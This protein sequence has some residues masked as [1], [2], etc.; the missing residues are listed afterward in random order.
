VTEHS[1]EIVSLEDRDK[2]MTTLEFAFATDPV[3]RWL[4][5]SPGAFHAAFS[6]FVNA[7]AGDAFDQGTA[8]WVDDGRGVA[9]WLPPGFGADDDA[10]VQVI[11]ESVNPDLLTDLSEFSDLLREYHPVVDHW[12]LAVT[13]VDPYC[14]GTGLGS[15][16]LRHALGRCDH[17]GLPAYLE[18]STLRNRALYERFGFKEIGVIQAG[19]SPQVWAMMRQPALT[20]EGL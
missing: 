12:Y 5:P 7:M 8:Q 13:G 11:L 17:D 2:A 18:A 10:L 14:Q 9:L 19:T 16:L 3:M 4:W 20:T 6:K 15:T 1:V